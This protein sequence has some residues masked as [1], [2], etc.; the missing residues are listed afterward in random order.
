VVLTGS[1]EELTIA[2][3]HEATEQLRTERRA[4]AVNETSA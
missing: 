4:A 1:L 3:D 2:V